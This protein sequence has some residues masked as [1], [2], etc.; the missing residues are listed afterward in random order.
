[1]RSDPHAL[2]DHSLKLL[3][4]HAAPALVRLAEIAVDPDQIR[5]ED[6]AV[7]LPEHRADTIMLL[8]AEDDP[9][10]WGWHRWD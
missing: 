1:M 4:R 3:T 10:R 8:G 6:T 5:F 9:D 2:L 7:N